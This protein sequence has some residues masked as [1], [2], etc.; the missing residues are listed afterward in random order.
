[1]TERPGGSDVSF[2]ETLATPSPSPL[3]SLSIDGS[4][5]GSWSINGFKWFSSATDAQMAILLARTP[6]GKLSTF[7]APMRRTVGP[8]AGLETEL[9][10][11]QIQRLKSKLGTKALPTAELEIKDMRAHLMGD[12]GNGIREI[13]TILN[14]TRVHN[15]VSAMGS[16]GRGLAIKRAFARVRKV[17]G[18]RRLVDMPSHVGIMAREEV[19]YRGWM[20]VT[21]FTVLL[22]GISEQ[23]ASALGKG[24]DAALI[25]DVKDVPLLLRVLTP[26][27]KAGSAKACIAG[28]QECVEGLGGVGYCENEEMDLNVARLYRDSNV[29]SI[30]EGTTETLSWDLVKILK[31]RNGEGILGALDRWMTGAT[32]G[33][34]VNSRWKQWAANVRGKSDEELIFDGRE[35]LFELGRVVGAVLLEVDARRDGDEV[36]REIA[37]RWLGGPE[38]W[39]A[40]ELG[41][42]QERV[43]MNSKIV[44][45]DYA[46]GEAAS[47]L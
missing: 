17:A 20:H 40:R 9:N 30:W 42:L 8:P 33:P 46:G 10:G 4:P 25:P 31:G 14:I 19:Q 43:T 47:K 3:S 44:F 41:S 6:E 7:F 18:G 23:E 32:V 37:E 22:L 13:S 39:K 11:V 34:E 2:S 38:D 12:A 21:F 35:V 16:W 29:L 28:L 15:S 26:V 1:M 27:L 45:G 36:A 5:L 24:V